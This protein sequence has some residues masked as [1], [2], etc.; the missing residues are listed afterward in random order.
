MKTAEEARANLEL[1]VTYIP[2][3][4]KTGVARADWATA[5][6]SDQAEKNFADSM[7]KAI[8]AKK[9]QVGVRKV[10]NAAWQA[11]AIEKGGAVI[12]DR[13]R[14]AIPKQAEK[15]A[16]I[17][18]RV[19]ADVTRLPPKTIDFRANINNRVTG[20]V[21]SWKKHSGKL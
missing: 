19:Q 18:G 7:A 2:E 5:A 9:R 13:I 21:E 4:Y 12:G 10:T 8:T 17:Y 11:L 20:T 6:G 16:P 14:T 3:R 15:W 1:S